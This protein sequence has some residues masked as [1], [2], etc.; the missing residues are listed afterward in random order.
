MLASPPRADKVT[1][2]VGVLHAVVAESRHDF[3]RHARPPDHG[4]GLDR[5][6]V[7]EGGGAPVVVGHELA[8]AKLDIL[9]RGSVG[10]PRLIYP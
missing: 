5:S 6:A 1:E 2:V 10:R 9:K 4:A 7:L 3:A 8:I